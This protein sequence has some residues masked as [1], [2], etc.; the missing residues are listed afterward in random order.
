MYMY[1]EINVCKNFANWDMKTTCIAF[2]WQLDC[3][4]NFSLYNTNY[5]KTSK[6]KVEERF[7]CVW[8][9]ILALNL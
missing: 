6:K 3:E 4:W 2:I 7:K 5:T 8:K 1:Y 9:E